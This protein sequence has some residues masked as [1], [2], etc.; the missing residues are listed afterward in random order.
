MHYRVAGEAQADALWIDEASRQARHSSESV[1]HFTPH[2]F[3]DAARKTMGAIDLDPA[4]C[5]AFPGR[6]EGE[7]DEFHRP[8]EDNG[9]A[10]AA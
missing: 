5:H 1:D 2:E 4:S 6:Q 3:V 9:F 10:Q 8:G 7:A